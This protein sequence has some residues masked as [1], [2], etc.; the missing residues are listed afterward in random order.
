MIDTFAAV[1]ATAVA[2]ACAL[3]AVCWWDWRWLR[4]PNWLNGMAFATSCL[5]A[6]QPTHSLRTGL[7]GAFTW[8]AI[9]WLI[10]SIKPGAFGGGDIK[11]A[12]STGLLSSMS[13][14]SAVPGIANALAGIV[15]A[16]VVTLLFAAFVPDGRKRR[17]LKHPVPHGPAMVISALVVWLLL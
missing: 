3:A 2:T 8:F 6:M 7:I 12:A 5:V 9:Y 15:G 13:A 11:L 14:S 1:V 16:A 4:V 10:A 17:S